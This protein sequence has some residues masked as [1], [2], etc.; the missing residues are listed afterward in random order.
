MINN[1]GAK[2][3]QGQL[4]KIFS[5]FGAPTEESWP[6]ISSYAFYEPEKYIYFE[7]RDIK[8]VF[9]VLEEDANAEDLALKCLSLRPDFRIS[10]KN[11]MNHSYFKCL[12][13]E[14][15]KLPESK[16]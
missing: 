1:A 8:T 2:D 13:P 14:I 7:R 5:V 16:F 3:P 9:K 10:A 11:A 6:N 12:P 4:C 15:L